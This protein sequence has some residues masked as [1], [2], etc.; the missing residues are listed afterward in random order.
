M[1]RP[2]FGGLRLE[3]LVTVDLGAY[4]GLVAFDEEG[5]IDFRQLLQALRQQRASR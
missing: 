2:A 4:E 3:L 1:P 5:R